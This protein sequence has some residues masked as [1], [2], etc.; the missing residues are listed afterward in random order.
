LRYNFHPGQVKAWDSRKRIVAIIAGGRSG[1]TSF[2]PMWLHREMQRQGPGDYNLA[3]LK[4]KVYDPWLAAG[5]DHPEIDVIRFDSTENPAFPPQEME[6]A[7]RALPRWKFDMQYRGLFT[8]PAGL[9]YESF[10]EARHVVQR[11]AIPEEW[12]ERYLGIDFGGVHT[13]ALFYARD[14]M[15]GTLYL[16]REYRA[17]GR[18]AAEHVAA[19][20]RIEPRE[21]TAAVGGSH[22]EG[23]WR[24]EFRAAGLVVREPAVK[25][26]EIGIDRVYG[27][28]RSDALL[29]FADLEGYLDEKQS[30]SRV[31]D[32]NGDTTEKIDD[33]HSY[34]AMD[35]ERYIL[36][37]LHEHD[38]AG[39]PPMPIILGRKPF[40]MGAPPW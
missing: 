35:A 2:A 24:A 38:D 32:D 31:L 37:W 28:H 6:R 29:V 5:R 22:S 11:F 39:D 15:K 17:G 3:W 8:R 10:D 1:K 27:F 26:V 33:P 21:F 40:S 14:P 36:G 4:Q 13:V 9:I 16:Y 7:R 30:Y 25:E 19:I 23:Q 34:H 20:R 18:T 12:G